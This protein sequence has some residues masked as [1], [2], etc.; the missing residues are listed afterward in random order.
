M[1]HERRGFGS[2]GDVNGP[3]RLAVGAVG[4][5]RAES[6]QA[7]PADGLVREGNICGESVSIRR[8]APPNRCRFRL[9]GDRGPETPWRGYGPGRG[10]LTLGRNEMNGVGVLG[11]GVHQVLGLPAPAGVPHRQGIEL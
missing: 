7:K 3:G 4:G 2:N 5:E 6:D 10:A 8:K 1:R 11:R 9:K